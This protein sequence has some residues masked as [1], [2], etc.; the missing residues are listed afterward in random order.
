MAISVSTNAKIYLGQY[1]LS[2][3]T[4]QA[5]LSYGREVHDITVFGDT[6]RKRLGGLYSATFNASGFWEAGGATT[7]YTDEAG[8]SYLGVA[9]VPLT[10]GPDGGSAGSVAHIINSITGDYTPLNAPHGQP[11]PF[12]ISGQGGG[13]HWG[14]GNF[15][16]NATATGTG[17]GSAVQVGAVGASQKLYA[18]LHILAVSGGPSITVKVQSDDN[19]NFTSATDRITFTAQ[20]A[21]GYEIKNVA[22]AITDDYWRYSISA[23][24]GTSV[25]FVLAVG[26]GPA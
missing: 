20:T 22:G 26:I 18:S 24:S 16:G 1:D 21:V 13:V 2:G 9:G 8:N 17:N 11:M 10:V 25:S 5:T 7:G 15:L 4:N 19:S 14:K 23:F 12:T 6:T 3:H